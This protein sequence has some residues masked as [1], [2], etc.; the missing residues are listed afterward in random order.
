MTLDARRRQE[1]DRLRVENM[2]LVQQAGSLRR[3]VEE[4]R[5]GQTEL[6]SDLA[7]LDT[8]VSTL[9]TDAA[10][11]SVA[12]STNSGNISSN[13]A[14]IATNTADIATNVVNI[15]ANL[16]AIGTNTG[17]IAT[18]VA[19]ISDNSDDIAT[20]IS[21]IA[22]NAAD[23]ATNISDI[24]DNAADI[25]TLD[26][27][28]ADRTEIFQAAD[29]TLTGNRI[30][31]ND[32]DGYYTLFSL[33]DVGGTTKTASLL[34]QPT[35]PRFLMSASETGGNPSMS[36]A[37]VS[38]DLQYTFTLGAHHTV[39]GDAGDAG[40]CYMS[41][42]SGEAP[43]W[44]P[45]VMFAQARLVST[46]FTSTEDASNPV[47]AQAVFEF[48]TEDGPCP[49]I[50]FDTGTHEFTVTAV[51]EGADLCHSVHSGLDGT[52]NR[53]TPFLSL[54]MYNTSTLVWDE[55]A[56]DASYSG[57]STGH[58]NA[59]ASIPGFKVFAVSEGDR[60]RVREACRDDGGTGATYVPERCWWGITVVTR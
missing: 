31:D 5:D 28:K 40:D 21:D 4:L 58:P 22:D 6:E 32:G 43:V 3:D 26:S 24:T 30:I 48:D 14:D 59:S 60:F 17:N 19:D 55:I 33:T 8:T 52:T 20:N 10:A 49:A 35:T 41:K 57:R 16:I 18:N 13:T 29:Q 53:Y 38:D 46:T 47:T 45:P 56:T 11:T 44:Q 37:V 54:E 50:S 42:G 25:L 2:N 15:A 39:N 51:G 23:I 34:C 36:L 1:F 7:T 27:D 9:A 12:V